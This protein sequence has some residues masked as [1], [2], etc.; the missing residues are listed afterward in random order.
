MKYDLKTVLNF[1]FI[2]I[3]K[4]IPRQRKHNTETGKSKMHICV[5][6]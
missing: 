1:T 4:K 5:Y 2:M 6:I 3:K